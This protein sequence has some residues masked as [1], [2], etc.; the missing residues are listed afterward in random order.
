M[1]QQRY[2]CD[3]CGGICSEDNMDVSWECHEDEENWSN[4][5]CPYC[6][7]RGNCNNVLTIG[8][9]GSGWIKI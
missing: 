2:E 3:Q 9:I 7:M 1:D 8:E 4:W 5:V 6:G